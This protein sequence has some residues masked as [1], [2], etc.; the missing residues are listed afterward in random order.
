MSMEDSKINKNIAKCAEVIPEPLVGMGMMNMCLSPKI[1]ST[2]VGLGKVKKPVLVPR[3]YIERPKPLKV[4][5]KLEILPKVDKKLVPL[6]GNNII[7]IW[8]RAETEP[9]TDVSKPNLE[10]YDIR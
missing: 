2:H 7:L 6:P 5:S 10:L 4:K 9:S 3:V 8:S 1:K